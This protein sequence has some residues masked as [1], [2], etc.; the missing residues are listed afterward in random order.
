MGKEIPKNWTKCNKQQCD[1]VSM[2]VE[3]RKI[4]STVLRN[5]YCTYKFLYGKQSNLLTNVSERGKVC[6]RCTSNIEA[7]VKS[8]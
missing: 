1:Q 3:R 2:L 4:L 8:F 6:L 5:D 7:G